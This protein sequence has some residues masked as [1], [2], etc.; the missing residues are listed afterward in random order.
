M[1]FNVYLS[2][3]SLY[4]LMHCGYTFKNEI[5][6]LE[7]TRESMARELVNQANQN[8]ELEDK[9]K[10]LPEALRKYKVKSKP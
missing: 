6:E 2:V 7:H 3:G 8:Q 9:A 4:Y 10:E 1:L 5:H